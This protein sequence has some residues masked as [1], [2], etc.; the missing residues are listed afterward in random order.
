MFLDNASVQKAVQKLRSP[1][2]WVPACHVHETFP[3]SSRPVF[4]DISVTRSDETGR[5]RTKS[6]VILV[7]GF[8]ITPAWTHPLLLR[9][10]HAR[11][12]RVR[13]ISERQHVD[14]DW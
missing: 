14:K 4:S 13:D 12:P 3:G 8:P 10:A 1:L 2:A 11:Y 6:Y 7:F 9:I 5:G